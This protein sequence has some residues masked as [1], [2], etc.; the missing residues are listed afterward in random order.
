MSISTRLIARSIERIPKKEK[1]LIQ[2]ELKRMLNLEERRWNKKEH[3]SKF[4]LD[5]TVNQ[6]RQLEKVPMI[7][8]D[9]RKKGHNKKEIIAT[10]N[11]EQIK[12]W[13][14]NKRTKQNNI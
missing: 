1:L 11:G 4:T 6:E 8:W 2:E 3:D 12:E 13:R 5:Q 9:K 10:N 14:I 7:K